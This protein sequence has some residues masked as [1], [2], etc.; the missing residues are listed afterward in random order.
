MKAL[1]IDH[2]GPRL[3]AGYA[4][5]SVADGAALVRVL[6]VGLGGL[7]LAAVA[8]RIA[9]TG[10]LG[11]EIV[12]RVEA[13]PA[14]P[15]LEGEVVAIDPELPCGSCDRCQS[16]MPKHCRS[17]RRLGFGS[18]DGGLAELIAV[19]RRNLVRVPGGVETELA[20]LAQPVAD[21]VHVSR[22]V[23]VERKTYV[24]VIGDGASALLIAQILAARNASVRLLGARPD[25]FGL[26]ERWR[27][28]HRDIREAGLRADQDV[29]VACFDAE[30]TEADLCGAEAAERALGM[31]RPR[32]TLV[33]SGPAV[34]IEGVGLDLSGG[35]EAVVAGELRVV[36][37]RRGMI[38]EGV[39]AIASGAVDLGPLVT[40]RSK[41]DEGVGLLR[42]AADPSQLR[43]L[44]RVA[45]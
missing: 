30:P 24:T 31:L 5:P 9:H 12:G 42:T 29:V 45:A 41:L 7:D 16:G 35:A 18:T 44:V 33:V 23:P 14:D 6:C 3:D 36:G 34:P 8:G 27:I 22:L 25:R 39:G 10:V 11:H 43:T 40:A 17:M 4:V 37:S 20:V 1:L 21:A 32:G 19:P 26:C 38:A 2:R 13:C 15:S 28:R